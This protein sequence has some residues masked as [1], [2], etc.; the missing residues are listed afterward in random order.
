M[1]LTPPVPAE[2]ASR[3]ITPLHLAYAEA[4]LRIAGEVVRTGELPFAHGVIWR[5]SSWAMIPCWCGGCCIWSTL[6]RVA[7]CPVMCCL[8]GPGASCSDNGCTACSDACIASYVDAIDERIV[9]PPLI[10][11]YVSPQLLDAITVVEGHLRNAELAHAHERLD[12]LVVAPLANI[13]EQSDVLV[14]AQAL[15]RRLGR[16]TPSLDVLAEVR[17][18]VDREIGTRTTQIESL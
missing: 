5:A 16:P 15:G 10:P 6:W 14:Q 12:R 9:V 3:Q 1:S 13:L 7:A 2:R 18:R 17:V 4:V 8:H 11:L